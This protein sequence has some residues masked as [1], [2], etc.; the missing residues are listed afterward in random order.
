MD[1]LKSRFGSNGADML[2]NVAYAKAYNTNHLRLLL[3]A[4]SMMIN[5]WQV[6]S[7]T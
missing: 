3:E 5:T 6:E 4:A 1:F 7:P 2:E